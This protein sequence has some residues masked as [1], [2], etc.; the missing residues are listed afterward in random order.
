MSAFP[1]PS[2]QIAH[3]MLDILSVH[4]DVE[5]GADS[6]AADLAVARITE[7]PDAVDVTVEADGD[8]TN[9]AIGLSNL[10]GA[11]LATLQHTVDLLAEA[12]GVDAETV[13]DEL[14]AHLDA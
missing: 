4:P 11:S 8:E 10:L 5:V 9:I 13:L 2:R 3:V 12:R 7:I 14:R 1:Q 6:E